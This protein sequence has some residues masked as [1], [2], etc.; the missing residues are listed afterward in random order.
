VI[1]L[2]KAVPYQGPTIDHR[3]QSLDNTTH[4]RPWLSP[5]GLL[6]SIKIQSVNLTTATCT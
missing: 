2:S 1:N 5:H 3:Y 6:H 4:Q